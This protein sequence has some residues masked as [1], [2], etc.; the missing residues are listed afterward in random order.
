MAQ[1][2]PQRLIRAY[3]LPWKRAAA[4]SNEFRHFG[5]LM[6]SCTDC[7]DIRLY[8]PGRALFAVEDGVHK[9]SSLGFS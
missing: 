4:T 6:E 8:A 9:N 7:V 1:I 2:D 3:V 5:G